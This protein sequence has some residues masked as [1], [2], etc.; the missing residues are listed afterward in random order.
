MEAF[1]AWFLEPRDVDGHELRVVE[2][3]GEPGDIVLIH[4]FTLHAIAENAGTGPRMMTSKNLFRRG[5]R[6]QLIDD[7]DRQRLPYLV[8]L[9][10]IRA[11]GRPSI[12]VERLAL[13][14]HGERADED[15]ERPDGEERPDQDG[16]LSR[17]RTGGHGRRIVARPTKP[18]NCRDE[19]SP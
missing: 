6:V 12:G 17:A 15:D 14:P 13:H 18:V 9:Q 8:V 4:P 3:T 5:V 19:R 11:R 2:L 1:R 10:E 7:V 16:A